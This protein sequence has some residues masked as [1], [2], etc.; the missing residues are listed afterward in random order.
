MAA[1][2]AR[3]LVEKIVGRK[4]TDPEWEG[5][6]RPALERLGFLPEMVKQAALQARKGRRWEEIGRGPFGKGGDGERAYGWN[7]RR[8]G[9]GD[10]RRFAALGVMDPGLLAEEEVIAL[11]AI[12]ALPPRRADDPRWRTS[13]QRTL[14]RLVGAGLLEPV[15]ESPGMYRLH[16]LAAEFALGRLSRGWLGGWRRERALRAHAALY[17]QWVKAD[18][19]PGSDFSLTDRLQAQWQAVLERGWRSVRKEPGLRYRSQRAGARILVEMVGHLREYFEVRGLYAEG[20]RWGERA[21]EAA[22]VDGDQR[23]EAWALWLIGRMAYFQDDYPEAQARYKEALG[24][25]RIIVDRQGEAWGL[26]GLGTVLALQGDYP[27]ARV[28][29]RKALEI[30][31]DI[32]DYLGEAKC[33]RGMGEVLRLQGDH[34]EAEAHY[35]EALEI[36]WDIGDRQGEAWGLWG[37]GGV[38]ALQGD[39][40]RAQARYAAAL[41]IFRSIGNRQGEAL[42][43]RNLGEVLR[44]QKRFSEAAACLAQALR[45]ARRLGLRWEESTIWGSAGRLHHDRGRLPRSVRCYERALGIAR[46]IGARHL[47]G[48]WLGELG[49]AYLDRGDREAGCRYLQEALA[50]LDPLGAPEAVGVRLRLAQACGA[51][52]P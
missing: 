45:L 9:R 23:G 48:V 14:E 8:L 17:M 11:W 43:L 52:F 15:G 51:A 40:P 37:L 2:E 16:P 41:E 10:R 24:I 6:I 19:R 26:W 7:Y 3:R 12:L 22:R 36:P 42:C 47:E 1:E 30:F 21:L 32:G 25:F 20:R 31:W 44:A 28:R 29:Y 34:P 27:E 13:C 38:L 46:A 4:I 18:A 49:R 39:Y 33:L 35:K 5:Q 50:V